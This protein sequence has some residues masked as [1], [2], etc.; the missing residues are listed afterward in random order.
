MVREKKVKA[1][2]TI[3]EIPI[4]PMKMQDLLVFLRFRVDLFFFSEKYDSGMI[5]SSCHPSTRRVTFALV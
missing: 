2:K 4:A 5:D 3:R 1:D